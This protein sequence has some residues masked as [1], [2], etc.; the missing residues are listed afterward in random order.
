MAIRNPA[1]IETMQA[2]RPKPVFLSA[3][4]RDLVMLSYEVDPAILQPYVPSGTILDS[5][6]GKTY[7]SLVGFRFCRT[8]MFGVFAIPFHSNF[9]EVNLH[10]YVRR[11]H[12]NED[13]RGVVFISEVVPR[14]AIATTARLFY[15]ENYTCHPMK[16]RTETE[17]PIQSAEYQWRVA[18]MWCKLFAK[19][20]GIPS[21]AVDGSLEQFITEHY[22]GYSRQ[23][24]GTSLEYQVTHP[25]W[26]V[27]TATEASF[28]G[29]AS[30]LYGSE[31]GA[32]LQRRPDCTF[33]TD[34]SAVTVHKGKRIA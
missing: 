31:F 4:W 27:W 32:I 12:K 7:V 29:D 2:S 22:W 5:S 24:N 28:D 1:A 11:R 3:E 30:A 16:H 33:I 23:R 8:K 19:G 17:G 9:L 26:P 13:R 10:F 20:T 21:L 15:G 25:S 14:R 6:Q 18:G 34:G